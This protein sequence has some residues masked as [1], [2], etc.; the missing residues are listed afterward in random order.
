MHFINLFEEIQEKNR[1]KRVFFWETGISRSHMIIISELL[2]RK[3]GK[4]RKRAGSIF[5]L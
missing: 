2:K 4:S 1:K 5:N 3:I